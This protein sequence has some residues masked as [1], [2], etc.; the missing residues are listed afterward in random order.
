MKLPD[1]VRISLLVGALALAAC[2]SSSDFSGVTVPDGGG[3]LGGGGVGGGGG[4]VG[5]EPVMQFGPA[6]VSG[7]GGIQLSGDAGEIVF[8][9]DSD[10]LGA[11]PAEEYQ[12]F[13]LDIPT[14]NVTQITDG[15]AGAVV[16]LDQFDLT[17]NGESVVWV[18]SN[19]FAG[20]NPNNMDNI[21]IA[22]TSGAGISQVTDNTGGFISNPQIA[23][24]NTVVFT[25]FS[26]LTGDNPAG[27]KQIFSINADGTGLTQISNFTS[28]FPEALS[29]ADGGSRVAFEGSGD[30]FGT[31]A[32][33]TDE[34]FVMDVDG[35]NLTQITATSGFSYDPKLSDNGS[36]VAFTTQ[37][38]VF[39]GGNPD[40][41]YEMYV[42]QTDG[43]AIV[44][45]TNNDENSGT[46]SNGAPGAFNI[47]GNGSIVI[48]G[49]RGDLTGLNQFSST[50]FWAAT[51]GSV[52]QQVLRQGTVPDS[53]YGN[54]NFDA[55][56]PSIT[57]D[58]LGFAFESTV[59]YTSGSVPTFQKIYTTIR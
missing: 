36:L 23:G 46:F 11:N 59:N 7:F 20:M 55:E 17:D 48:F 42:A 22:S 45:I 47:S 19:D 40:G 52:I 56:N 25:S 57:N 54:Q 21:F 3:G 9:D 24:N 51:D 13:S 37:A 50:L 29:L 12:L 2:D 41:N 4:G 32:D 8:V 31:N 6:Q 53:V 39:A 16:S 10:T 34:I 5:F 27:D 58:G 15:S 35:N 44:Q 43:S 28:M 14:G 33:G 49:S 26:D 1:Y 18:S 38:E 30:P